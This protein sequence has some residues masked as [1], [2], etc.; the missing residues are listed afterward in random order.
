METFSFATLRLDDPNSVP[1]NSGSGPLH[2]LSFGMIALV[3]QRTQDTH[4]KITVHYNST[5]SFEITQYR[6]NAI[7]S[8]LQRSSSLI[9][10]G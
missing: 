2:E 4:F 3:A 10:A 6:N 7:T 8:S 5:L 1:E 9:N